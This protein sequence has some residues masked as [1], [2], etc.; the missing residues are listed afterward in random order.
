MT[1]QYTVK[2]VLTLR[3]GWAERMVTMPI[4]PV[5][6]VVDCVPELLEPLEISHWVFTPALDGR[7]ASIECHLKVHDWGFDES[8]DPAGETFSEWLRRVGFR[9]YP[10]RE[11][12]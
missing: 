10:A 9:V 3:G 6:T 7:E 12:L 4:M 8:V 5:G 11:T 1:E 2:I